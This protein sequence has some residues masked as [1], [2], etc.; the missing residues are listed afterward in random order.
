MASALYGLTATRIMT[1]P[2]D[3]SF[4]KHFAPTRSTTPARRAQ[5]KQ[6]PIRSGS[7]HTSPPVTN[8]RNESPAI[9]MNT[10]PATDQSTPVQA[11]SSLP[12][13]AFLFGA[14]ATVAA[15]RRFLG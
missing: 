8:R 9:R 6:T 7:D 3:R 11:S 13:T 14:T 12:A 1:T 4:L 5:P 2:P 10:P 15:Q